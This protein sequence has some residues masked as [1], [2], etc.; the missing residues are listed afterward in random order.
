MGEWQAVAGLAAVLAFDRE[1][2]MI[3]AF[4]SVGV[5]AIIVSVGAWI[6]LARERRAEPKPPSGS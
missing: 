5:A 2:L 6:L 1:T 3:G 4:G